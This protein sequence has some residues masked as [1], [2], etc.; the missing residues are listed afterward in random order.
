MA[1][2][3]MTPHAIRQAETRRI[4]PKFIADIV[5]ERMATFDDAVAKRKS[6]GILCGFVEDRGSLIG[7]NGNE[8]WA[9][10]RDSVITTTMFR[11]DNQPH[12]P[13][14]LRVDVV[15]YLPAR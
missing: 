1:R 9:I 15:L 10:L 2:F 13:A 12:T 3:S 7:S 4:D 8:V 11:R 5:E 6:F 14:A